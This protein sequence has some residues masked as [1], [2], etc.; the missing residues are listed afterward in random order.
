MPQ[1]LRTVPV[2]FHY[3]HGEH[4]LRFRRRTIEEDGH[5]EYMRINYAP[6]FQGPLDMPIDQVEPFYHAIK[7]FTQLVSHID[8]VY[9]TRLAP[10]DLV[11]FNN[12]RVLHG[13]TKF[14]P[15]EGERHLRGSY[16]ALDAFRDRWRV[17][18]ERYHPD[19][20]A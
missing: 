20:L 14:N 18:S 12:R 5:N 4:H 16:I 11:I 15:N 10:G 1:A 13:R 2:T 19:A 9:E 17:L 8:H 7:A 3:R 6:P